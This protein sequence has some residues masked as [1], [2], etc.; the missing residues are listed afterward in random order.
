MAAQNIYRPWQDLAI[1]DG[2]RGA[3]GDEVVLRQQN[4]SN[5][6][7]RVLYYGRD[8]YQSKK[9]EGQS[10]TDFSPWVNE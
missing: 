7:T 9:P 5:P 2:G 6:T 1:E 8:Y 3:E 10:S 4:H